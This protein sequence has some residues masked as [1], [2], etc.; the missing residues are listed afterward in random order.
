MDVG[1]WQH[2]RSSGGGQHL[3]QIIVRAKIENGLNA[4]RFSVSIDSCVKR[5]TRWG[6]SRKAI[7]VYLDSD[8]IFGIS[9]SL[10]SSCAVC[11]GQIGGDDQAGLSADHRP[12]RRCH[13]KIAA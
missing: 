1:A 4:P 13:P 8:C 2:H 10:I 5:L 7:G 11:G 3:P 12:F 6:N 9:V